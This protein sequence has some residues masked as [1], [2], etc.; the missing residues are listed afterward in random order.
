MME[1]RKENRY[2]IQVIG[3]HLQSCSYN[4]LAAIPVWMLW[5]QVAKDF[6][7][8]REFNNFGQCYNPTQASKTDLNHKPSLI[9][10]GYVL[11]G[12]HPFPLVLG[13]RI[14]FLLAITFIVQTFFFMKRGIRYQQIGDW[15]KV[16]VKMMYEAFFM[17]VRHFINHQSYRSCYHNFSM[18]TSNP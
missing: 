5:G 16:Q 11:T 2:L 6:T 18:L 15:L 17:H 12:G 14:H 13:E 10:K 1:K 4:T 8:D 9:S 7:V 3:V